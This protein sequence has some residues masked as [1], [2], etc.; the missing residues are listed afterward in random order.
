M[1]KILNSAICFM[2]VFVICLLIVGSFPVKA[3]DTSNE[4]FYFTGGTGDWEGVSRSSLDN[5]KWPYYSPE[6]TSYPNYSVFIDSTIYTYDLSSSISRF[7]LAFGFI[8]YYYRSSYGNP[9]QFSPDLPKNVYYIYSYGVSNDK[10]GLSRSTIQIAFSSSPLRYELKNDKYCLTSDSQIFILV[11]CIPNSDYTDSYREGN[12]RIFQ[13]QRSYNYSEFPSYDY[14]VN[15]TNFYDGY[16][17]NTFLDS[18]THSITWQE[19]YSNC[20]MEINGFNF[21]NEPIKKLENQ[22]DVKLTPEFGIDMDRVFDKNTGQ[23]DYF[24]FE[25]TNNS[26]TNIQFCAYI[27]DGS[28]DSSYDSDHSGASGSWGS[29]SNDD[30]THFSAN[31]YSLVEKS[32]WNYITEMSYYMPNFTD[33]KKLFLIHNYNCYA[34]LQKGNFYWVLLKP[35]EHFEDYI[36]WENVNIIAQIN[37]TFVV[38]CIPT[39]LQYSSNIFYYKNSSD[40]VVYRYLNDLIEK[41]DKKYTWD[42]FTLSSKFSDYALDEESI[43]TVYHTKFSCLTMPDFSSKI[44]GGNSKITSNWNDTQQQANN[45]YYRYDTETGEIKPVSDWSEFNGNLSD[46]DINIDSISFNNVKEYITF[47]KQF[48]NLLKTFFTEFPSLWALIIF[49]LSACVTIAIVR[50]IKG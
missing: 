44:K 7:K 39:D 35:G 41:K 43:V 27:N 28:Y 40:D 30:I 3:V 48:I 22:I 10:N 33:D 38:Q 50:F 46:F 49:G 5:F 47:P 1:K 37:Y 9:S 6:L 20:D 12:L 36:Y 2:M 45:P 21:H 23:N 19:I 24:K 31:G 34:E 13:S 14:S 29:D 15:C 42:D 11:S 16:Y 4:N 25:V 8:P 26:D 32:N 18:F 17:V